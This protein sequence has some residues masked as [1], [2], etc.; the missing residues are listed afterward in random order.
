MNE[1]VGRTMGGIALA[2]GVGHLALAPVPHQEGFA[3]RGGVE[4]EDVFEVVAL[5]DED[6][7]SPARVLDLDLP[8]PMRLHGH[9]EF[10]HDHQRRFI[11]RMVDQ[12]ADTGRA[13]IGLAPCPRDF[14]TK[15]VFRNRAA[16]DVSGANS[17]DVME[18]GRVLPKAGKAGILLG[19]GA[20]CRCDI[21]H[22]KRGRA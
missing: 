7:I 15:K 10:A 12:R 19:P 11:G 16:A 2:V 8:R 4:V 20:R 1:L 6:Q 9:P 14:V 3:A 5:H 17:E 18:H 22:K 21:R 13:Y